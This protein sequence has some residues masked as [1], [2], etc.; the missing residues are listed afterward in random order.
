MSDLLKSMSYVDGDPQ[1]LP[2]SAISNAD[3]GRPSVACG[4]IKMDTDFGRALNLIASNDRYKTFLEVGTWCGLGSTKCLLDGIILRDDGAKLISLESNYKF[5]DITKKYW[6]KFFEV[7]GI[8]KDKFDIQYGSLVSYE[9]LDENYVTDSG[10]TKSTYDYNQD[11]KNAP[12]ITIED[13]VDVLC[14]DGGHFSTSLEWDLFKETVKVVAIDDTSTSK[15]NMI[16]QEIQ[17]SE[18]WR[19]VYNSG[20]RNG[21]MIVEAI[22]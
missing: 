7:H 15:T 21:E 2:Y 1:I 6:K 11:I 5:Y 17:Q 10:Q 22:E 16:L 19:V 20:K 9:E 4:Q 14:L 13:R 3:F 12:K 8:E 18:K